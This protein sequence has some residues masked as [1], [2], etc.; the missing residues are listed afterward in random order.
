MSSDVVRIGIVGCGTSP[1]PTPPP[2]DWP[3]G[4][5]GDVPRNVELVAA[6][7]VDAARADELA[8]S[9]GWQRSASDSA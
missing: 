6:T 3:A 7:D 2:T 8:R 5:Y 1:V 4:T 9:W